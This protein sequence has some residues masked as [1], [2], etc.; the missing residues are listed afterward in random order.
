MNET[1]LFLEMGFNTIIDFKG[2][3]NIE[4]ETNEREYLWITIMLSSAGD[5]T[6]LAPLVIAKGE[7]DKAVETKL[8]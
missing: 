3:K 2:N 1:G 6:K 4:I 7:P 5:G 8:R